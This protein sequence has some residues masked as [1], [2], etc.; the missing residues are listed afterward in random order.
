MQKAKRNLITS[1]ICLVLVS[2]VLGLSVF[3][4][5]QSG[6][7]I[8]G[9]SFFS[10]NDE[11]N[12]K[13]NL[14]WTDDPEEGEWQS[15]EAGNNNVPFD[16]GTLWE[17]DHYE[18]RYFKV[19]NAGNYD[20]QY[21]LG[22]GT[23]DPET[24]PLAYI[25]EHPVCEVIDVF[26]FDEINGF[27]PEDLS[28]ENPIG[29]LED[30][31]I[32]PNIL[33]NVALNA[34]ESKTCALVF[35]MQHE[36]GNEYQGV[37]SGGSRTNNAGFRIFATASAEEPENPDP[38]Y[39]GKLGVAPELS[40]NDTDR[41]EKFIYRV[42]T[43]NAVYARA[44]FGEPDE[45]NS[46]S[47]AKG[48][49]TLTASAADGFSSDLL[50]FGFEKISGTGNTNGTFNR[51]TGTY[52]SANDFLEASSFTFTGNGVLKITM[53]YNNQPQ[54]E[55][56]VEVVSGNNITPQTTVTPTLWNSGN[57]I[58]FRNFNFSSAYSL[59]NGRVLYGNGFTIERQNQDTSG[60]T[61]Y[62]LNIYKGTVDNV[63]LKGAVY[64][65]AVQS[66]IENQGYAPGVFVSGDANIYNSFISECRYAVQ[67]LSGNVLIK[68]T[69]VSGG[70]IANIAVDGGN[71][72]LEDCTTST[73]PT[74]LKGLGIRV[75]SANS[76][77]TIKGS[78]NQHNW[79]KSN[80]LPSQYQNLMS[81]IYNDS[82]YAYTPSGSSTKYVNMGIAFVSDSGSITME[83]A[84][85]VIKDSAF[86]NKN[87]YGYLEKTYMGVTGAF[88]TA[89]AALGSSEML[90]QPDYSN[91]QYYTPPA[92][93]FDF[94]N[95]N[96]IPKVAGDNNY[97][98]Y[99]SN[100]D[101]V[102]ISFD[103][104]DSST[105][106]TWDPMILTAG[107]YGSTLPYTV[108][109]GSTDYTDSVISF[110]GSGDYQ[111]V[112]TYT[113]ESQYVYSPD[114]GLSNPET[115][116]TQ[117]VNINVNAV[118]PEN[119]VYK[120]LFEYT[121]KWANSSRQVITNQSHT[122]VMPDV[123]ATV[124][125]KI[126]SRTIEGKTVFYPIVEVGP[127]GSSGNSDYESGKGYFFAPAFSAL[128]ITDYYQDTGN[129]Q[130]T[131]NKNT[132]TWPH[133]KSAISGPDT[134]VFSSGYEKTW[135]TASPY[136][137]SLS[138]QYYKYAKSN[139]GLCYTTNDLEKNKDAAEHLVTYHYKSNDGETY[140]YCIYYKFSAFTYVEGSCFTEGTKI[141][142]ADGSRKPIE[143]ITFGDSILSYNFFTGKTEAQ[144]IA[145]LVNHG[146]DYYKVLNL[147]FKDGTSL[148][149]IGDHGVFDYTLNKYVYPT[150]DDYKDYIG[151]K[152]VRF[153]EN[154]RYKK[155][156]LT[157]AYVTNEYTTAYSITSA[158]N[159]NALAQN[160]LT[161]APPDEFYNWI[162]MGRKMRYDTKQFNA[163]VGKYGLYDY[164]VF[165]DY[166][167]YDSFIAF[168]GPYLKVA[169]EKGKFTFDDIIHL[170]ELYGSYMK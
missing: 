116:Y 47:G 2:A 81:S 59:S 158:R 150:E 92:V 55:M 99:D 166:V 35:R 86:A 67:I 45:E 53:S 103:K 140:Y 124:E 32:S 68:N 26:A 134:D 84:K 167:S 1:I 141:T 91:A 97:C 146:K 96:Y 120:A 16:S 163:D 7:S 76:S 102:N 109:M 170:I 121:D 157:N 79:L 54:S 58:L 165:E 22:I 161:V 88:Y 133:G 30:C 110:A 52:T 5:S 114:G 77:L 111:V 93:T 50:T 82:T 28:G 89:K 108:T 125:N 51:A 169:V 25:E 13:V 138:S 12:F 66:G 94:T 105:V 137:C 38:G 11:I 145:L 155:I 142:L 154:G 100:T 64:T 127:T 136:S 63:I 69:T 128:N 129:V 85:A 19:D 139:N 119:V 104:T 132:A 20:F 61:G 98:Y 74:G 164:S 4:R 23:P 34:G 46:S 3:E 57:V 41:L 9:R 42:G 44:L 113:D 122:Y 112:Y 40:N 117:T 149:L 95:K 8:F 6:F 78:L 83:Q 15:A 36:A 148:R 106:F 73:S 60:A 39:D 24:D 143:D 101:T 126:G 72:T 14:S 130:Y 144:G 152:F 10:G 160:M 27:D 162:D 17:P 48:L 80:E 21:N 90:A 56:Y 31:F 62:L 151:H 131:Y 159:S 49:F 29:T 156:K 87:N 123:T 147:E 18:V 107:K 37:Y 75:T 115:T 153:G 43:G 71:V 118:E 70:A 135:G 65:S 168:N 33:S